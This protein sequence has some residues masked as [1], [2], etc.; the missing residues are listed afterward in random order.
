MSSDSEELEKLRKKIQQ[1]EEELE[2]EREKRKSIEEDF[3]EHKK[4]FDEHKKECAL[5]N[6]GTPAFVKE[7]ITRK[8][9]RVLGAPKNHKGYWRKIPE[10]ID[11]IK[12]LHVLAC[13]CCGGKLSSVQEVRERVI[14]DLPPVPPPVV[15]KYLIERRY[16]AQCKKLVEAEVPDALPGA[17]IG[18]RVMLLI[19]FL[20]IRMA[21]PENKIV[22]LLRNAHA[23][24]ISPAEVVC[25]L[26]QLR[27]AFGPHY[28]EIE[29]KIRDAPVKGCDE[30]GW[31]LNGVNHWVWCMVNEEVAW[32]KVHR[33]RSYKVVK[34][35]LQDQTGKLI[36]TDRLPTYTQL[37]EETGCAQQVC[38]AHIL[39][40]SKKLAKHYDEAATVHRRL[41]SI[42]RKAKSMAPD[43]TVQDV[44]RL[45]ARID[46]FSKLRFEH[47]S[48]RTFRNSICKKHRDNLFHF[49]TNPAVPSTNNGTERAI[50]KAVI[51]RKISNG[52]RSEKGARILETL[53]SVIETLR[54]QGK[55]PLDEM[56]K[57]L[58]SRA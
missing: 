15:T 49:V 48:I 58:A 54:L 56:R 18:L 51:I 12:Q 52:S 17:R 50:R 28:A 30:T 1:L 4:E 5:I 41:K 57:M 24:N 2:K 46:R 26:D 45:L 55:N 31:R 10:R 20:K 42:F 21:L 43:G 27:R 36:V 40:N 23:F 38:W 29:K 34:P 11:F 37:A 7:D 39:R 8:V 35:V 25:A 22:E 53:L 14:E 9:R 32:Y 13:P 44:E 47:K 33:R 16:C 19:A 6:K 3:K